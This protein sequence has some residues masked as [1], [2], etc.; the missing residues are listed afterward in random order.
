MLVC[1]ALLL[2]LFLPITVSMLG[3][4]DWGPVVAGYLASI[5]LA[6]AYAAIGL[7]LSSRTNNPLVALIMTAL[8]GGL[9]YLVG[10]SA[11]VDFV[12]GAPGDW[13]RAMGTGSRFDS[14]LRGVLDIRDLL[15]FLSLTGIFL[16]LNAVSLEGKRWSQGEEMAPA[17]NRV[18]V[19]ALLAVVNLLVLN[20]W[21]YPLSSLRVDMTAGREYSLS[22]STKDLLA[23]LDEPLLIR[24]YISEKT[25]PLLAP[26][27]PI[28]EDMLREYE[29]AGR[30]KVVAERVDPTQDPDL[31]QEANQ[32]YGIRPTPF[33]ISGRYEDTIINSYFDILI[34]YGDQSA[35]LNFQDLIEVEAQ[36]DGNVDVRLRNLE[37]DLTRAIKKAVYGFQSID[38]VLAALDQPARLTL[39]VTPKT[40][41]PDLEVAP[42][43]IRQVASEIAADANGKFVFETV[44]PTAEGS[45]VTANDLFERYGIQP[46]AVSLFSPE[47]FYLHMVLEVGD[48]A[49]V[50]FP[51]GD[52][53]ESEVRTAIE[54]ALKRSS[55]G[56]L[57]VV[58]IWSPP[59]I[60]T[61]DMFGNAQPPFTTFRTVR[62]QLRQEYEVREIDLSTGRV[63]PDVDVLL[64][65]APQNLGDKERFAIDQYL[66]RG[67]S[68]V[69]AV[70]N[71]DVSVDTFANTLV[72]NPISDGIDPLLNH[73][74][75]TVEKS[76]VMDVQNEPFPLPV[77]R[78]I[79]GVQVQEIQA[80]SYPFFVDIRSDGMASDSPI[81]SNLPAVTLNWASP[82][83]VD[84][85]KNEGRKVVELLR[86]SSQSW[87]R[88]DT[89]ITPDLNLY[90]RFGFPVEGEMK[91][92]LLAVSVQGS[93]ES[94]F[95]DNPLQPAEGESD[96][97]ISQLVL[98]QIDK[99]PETSRLVL[100]S[101]AQFLNDAVF[102][103]SSSLHGDRYLNNLQFI[104]NA[105]DWSAEDLDLLDIRA[106]GAHA[107]V[108]KPLEA[109]DQRFWEVANY[110]VALAALAVLALVWN[111]RRRHEQPLELVPREQLDASF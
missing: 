5:L 35:V 97:T 108:L 3:P 92:H 103:L 71:Y 81:V 60:P 25:H 15:Y 30:G 87:L 105:V 99:S 22:A 65:I 94:Y 77:V 64:L 31:E 79:G 67:G 52:I 86:S 9:F 93:F 34:R 43:T 111:S 102:S 58:G 72:L 24:A 41:P 55:P 107:R 98:G 27:A 54:S 76:L 1:V 90:P 17:R 46:Y 80:L 66:M 32:T 21:L 51:G 106:R 49:Q 13:L 2:T 11:V 101:S 84:E 10:S 28:V 109:S 75:L 20:V 73:Y 104:Q 91:S 61:R 74:G 29:I 78:N 7:F 48:Q 19:F 45:T 63:P 95:K 56:F 37:Y 83:T 14:I 40:L 39:Y 110:V 70:E 50:I 47:T 88:T 4:L 85:S 18:L 23:T 53:S 100:I 96:D 42:D 26:L 69:A 89:N 57:K 8:V 36:R 82:I 44:D 16:L 68:V 62:D 59:E 6:S 38:S 33:R 12:G